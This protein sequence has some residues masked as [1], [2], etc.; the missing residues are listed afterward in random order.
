MQPIEQTGAFYLGRRYDA[1]AGAPSGDL[2]MYDAR[3][4]T[5]HAVI[6]GMTGSGKT[7]LGI[8]LLEEAAIDGVPAI[9]ID[10]KGDIANLALTFPDLAAGDFAPWLD[11]EEAR[12]QGLEPAAHAEAVAA[13]WRQGLGE[14]GQ[15]GARIARLKAACAVTVFTPGSTAGEPVS[16]LASLQAPAGGFAAQEEALRERIRGT[17]G[18]LLGL[19]GVD[20]DPVRSPAHI[21]LATIIEHF[22]QQAQDVQ[23]ADLIRALQEPPVRTF[24]VFDVDTFFPA[25]E[26]RDLALALNGLMAAPGFAAWLQGTPLDIDTLLGSGDGRPRHAVMSIAHLDDAQR[27]FFVTLLLEALLAWSRRQAGTSSLRAVLYM[28]E[29][30]GFMPPTANPPSK[31]PLLTLLKQARASGLGVVLATQNPVDL[32]YKGLANAGTW[33]IG[34]LQTERDKERMLEGLAAAQAGASADPAQLSAMIGGLKSRVFLLH[35]VHEPAPVLMHTR[36][37]LS[38]LGGPLTRE[39]IRRLGGGSGLAPAQAAAAAMPPV[40]A[41]A[42]AAGPGAPGLVPAQGAAAGGEPSPVAPALPASV[43]QAFLPAAGAAPVYEPLLAGL[44]TVAFV[45][46]KRG[47][48]AEREVALALPAGAATLVADWTKAEPLAA[49]TADLAAQP[50]AGARF[51]PLPRGWDGAAFHKAAAK[52]LV[53]HLYQRERLEVLE[54]PLLKLVGEPGESRDAFLNRAR[55]AARERRDAEVDKLDAAMQVKLTRLETKQQAEQRDLAEDQAEL[56]ARKQEE[57]LSAG[58]SLLGMFGVLGRKRSPGLATA[59][60][61]RRMTARAAEDIAESQAQLAAVTAELERLRAQLQAD[62]AAINA[63]WEQALAQV[64]TREVAPR[65]TDVQPAFCGLLWRPAGGVRA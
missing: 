46:L 48:A 61:K 5:T 36:W 65:R 14:W 29:L 32:D 64:T 24:G 31:V 26:R 60:R 19:A 59:A 55:L 28:D 3:D 35:N 50:A 56:A 49:T 30:F 23:L 25:A 21:F 20:G 2:V 45:D 58:E 7:G 11:P 40:G 53:D 54:L 17:V 12:R 9:I 22:W 18:A 10:P 47:L 6:V 57:M 62:V 4:L 44:A 43:P 33:F 41:P 34:K 51:L 38:Y 1:V 52:G 8:S 37:T 39:Q 42:M 15:D 63:K 16:I 27:M 13:R